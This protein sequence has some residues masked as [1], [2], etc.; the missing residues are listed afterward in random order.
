MKK[1][2][3]ILLTVLMISCTEQPDDVQ[4]ECRFGNIT[5]VD[6]EHTSVI[7]LNNITIYRNGD[8]RGV[9]SR[10]GKNVKLKRKDYTSIIVFICTT[11]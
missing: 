5:I 3:V 2:L 6:G 9:S 10:T 8:I 4:S 11:P 1:Y 7:E